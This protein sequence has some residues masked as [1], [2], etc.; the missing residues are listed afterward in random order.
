M[1]LLRSFSIKN[2]RNLKHQLFNF[3]ESI[4]C[5]YGENGQG[6]TSIL[7][8]IQWISTL[9]SF[10][11]HAKFNDILT[12]GTDEHKI[13]FQ[14]LFSEP[15]ETYLS[16]TISSDHKQIYANNESIKK[17]DYP[18]F[19]LGPHDSSKFIDDTS[20][21]KAWFERYFS[22]IDHD[23]K[24]YNQ[25]Y[26]KLLK[27]KN[28]A[29]SQ[30]LSQ[31]VIRAYNHELS[32]LVPLLYHKRIE[33]INSINTII[34]SIY[35]AIFHEDF[36]LALFQDKSELEP[37]M[38]SPH[39]LEEFLNSKIMEETYRKRSLYGI[40]RL[41]TYLL[42]NQKRADLY[43]SSGQQKMAF[44]ALFF[45]IIKLNGIIREKNTPIVLID[46]VSGELDSR[47]WKN[48]I[49]YLE[50]TNY[51][52][53]ISTANNDFMQCLYNENKNIKINSVSNGEIL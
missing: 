12:F 47:R 14:A 31:S 9:K 48:F 37:Y 27:Q 15:E 41:D 33:I 50:M 42:I 30:S 25:K 19:F 45:A 8:A 34:E 6:K 52:I 18:I 49:K 11:K 1:I 28:S 5:F 24:T 44:F 43:S 29:Y 3:T 26:K 10:K 16:A 4:Q 53:V 51:Q 13:Q 7:E 22:I 39:Q 20:F 36:E 38:N 32:K 2:F 21:R 23:F 46:D 40:H 17:V 35:K